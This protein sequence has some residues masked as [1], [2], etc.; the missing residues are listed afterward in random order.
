MSL[1]SFSLLVAGLCI[2]V[3]LVVGILIVAVDRRSES[4]YEEKRQLVQQQ[5]SS[6]RQPA[7]VSA[8]EQEL[9]MVADN[10]SPPDV[11][12]SREQMVAEQESRELERIFQQD[13]DPAQPIAQPVEPEPVKAAPV[14]EIPPPAHTLALDP[15]YDYDELT[16]VLGVYSMQQDNTPEGRPGYVAGWASEDGASRVDLLQDGDNPRLELRGAD[17]DLFAEGFP[18][19]LPVL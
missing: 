6:Q 19:D 4:R 12:L 14:V 7:P 2:L 15:G 5:Y 11:E 9:Q 10:F 16:R 3:A 13:A 18:M 17:A 1:M 8:S